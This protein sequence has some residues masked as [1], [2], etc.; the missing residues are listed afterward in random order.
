[1]T[2]ALG[3]AQELY[4]ISSLIKLI[5]ESLV[6]RLRSCTVV[7]PLFAKNLLNAKWRRKRSTK[8][9]PLGNVYNLREPPA[10]EM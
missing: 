10:R 1:M 9:I 6:K 3:S 8:E 7:Y 2:F 4:R 5:P